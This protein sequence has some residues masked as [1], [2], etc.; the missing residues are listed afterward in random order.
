MQASAASDITAIVLAGGRSRRFGRDK[1]LE[2]IAGEPMIRRVIRRSAEPVDA[3]E[4]IVVV[5]SLE[6]ADALP[7]DPQH[8]TVADLFPGRGPLG[9]I[10]TGLLAARTGWGLVT[11]CDM[12]LL[13]AH[14]LRHM[15]R[16]RENVDV[17][18]PVVDGRPEPTHAL[19]S[20]RCL[21]AIK[22]CLHAGELKISG[23]FD[24]VRVRPILEDEIRRFD[25]ALSSF[26]NVNRP[27]DLAR[28]LDSEGPPSPTDA[29]EG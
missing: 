18:V 25:P 29:R 27:E 11:A 19:Y 28:I 5:S 26:L 14:L 6:R 9:G 8:R 24:R 15:S 22:E 10:Y 12:P 13:S 21:P 20:T 23:F 2:P 3:Y 1:A 16:L 17:I 7:L 4:V